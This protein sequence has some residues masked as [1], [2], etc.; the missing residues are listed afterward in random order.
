MQDREAIIPKKRTAIVDGIILLLFGAAL[1]WNREFFRNVFV[2]LGETDW[3]V[4]AAAAGLSVLYLMLDSY[5]CYR[6]CRMHNKSLRYRDSLEV[7]YITC[8]FRLLTFGSGGMPAKV[9]CYH[10]KGIE[11]GDATGAWLIQYLFYKLA[12]M[13][14]AAVLVLRTPELLFHSGIRPAV[15]ISGT[16]IALVVV[17]VLASVAVNEKMTEFLYR[18]TAGWMGKNEKIKVRVE[19]VFYQIRLLQKEAR[20]VLKKIPF[21]LEILAV[22]L[23]LVMAYSLIP[24]LVVS[25]NGAVPLGYSFQVMGVTNFL[26]GAI[27]LPSG[28][29][30]V[31]LIFYGMLKQYS[32]ELEAAG[33]L[34]ILRLFTVIIPCFIGGVLWILQKRRGNKN[35]HL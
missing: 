18:R 29:G 27:P 31:E 15:L 11:A 32:A 9:Y 17:F 21:S 4:L 8:F 3:R 12:V 19:K 6:I 23:L 28:Y 25:E 7:T 24:A 22:N 33:A 5:I 10:K 26:A 35:L 2:L 34:V 20:Y 1:F 14:F 16:G 13:G 30:S